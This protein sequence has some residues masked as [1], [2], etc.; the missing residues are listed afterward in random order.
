MSTRGIDG[1]LPP[2]S[3]DSSF[4]IT[5]TNNLNPSPGFESG[6]SEEPS[7]N[8]GKGGRGPIHMVVNGLYGSESEIQDRVVYGQ[9][10]VAS[11]GHGSRGSD[12]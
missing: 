4:T 10:D 2:I 9:D 5:C 6:H 12:I 3:E 1:C 8:K 7:K 11:R